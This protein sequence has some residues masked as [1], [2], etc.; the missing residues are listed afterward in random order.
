M[1]EDVLGYQEAP[2]AAEAAPEAPAGE[3]RASPLA[4]RLARERGIDLAR[5]TGTGPGGRVVE[6]DVLGYQEAAPAAVP[7]SEG[8]Q[9]E[10][11]G[12]ERMELSRMRQTIAKV[13]SDSKSQAPHFTSPP[14]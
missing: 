12:A 8:A 3:V 6:E 5:V 9:A 7:P 14:K 13:T 11:A 4:R 2:P 10:A 1:E